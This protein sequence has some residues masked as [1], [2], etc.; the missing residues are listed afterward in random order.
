MSFERAAVSFLD[1]YTGRLGRCILDQKWALPLNKRP[2]V[3]N[4]PFPDCRGFAIERKDADSWV[5]VPGAALQVFEDQ[6]SLSDL[7]SNADGLFLT[8]R[9]GWADAS[10]V[11]E[12]YKQIVRLLVAHWFVNRA[13]VSP[14]TAATAIPFGAEALIS[15]LCC[16]MG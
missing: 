15:P 4:L 13:A 2:D 12:D 3:V 7:P 6:V 1:G 5:E 10:N 11:P 16:V 9:A 14:S 8:F